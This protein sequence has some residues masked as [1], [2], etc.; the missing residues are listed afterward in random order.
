MKKTLSL[1]LM[2]AMSLFGQD[3]DILKKFDEKSI[4][5][6]VFIIIDQTTPL[7]KKIRKN[8]LVNIFGLIRPSNTV[9][10]FTFSE[11]TKGK[12]VS[13]VDRYHFY[14]EIQPDTRYKTSMDELEEYDSCYKS[15]FNSM[16]K[17]L[18]NDM[19]E[20]F[21]EDQSSKKSEILYSLK[22]VSN[23][24]VKL[25]TAN[26]KIVVIASDMLENSNY[27]TLYKNTD[28][29]NL[30]IKKELSI[31]E[32]ENLFGDFNNADIIVAGAGVVE[33][34]EDYRNGKQLDKLEELWNEYFKKSNA[35][36][37]IF[38][39]ELERPLS[40]IYK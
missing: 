15:Y 28:L 20:N 29:E 7:T 19:L 8:I 40:E 5:R 22:K 21:K 25:S 27:L 1:V 26:K 37:I 17:K 16:Q 24:A 39:Q 10:L 30:D 34:E 23:K 6:E 3:C 32:K 14:S 2:S 13:L 18:A 35:N 31:I 33:K 4:Q 36:P 9:N 38:S 11:Y 12:N